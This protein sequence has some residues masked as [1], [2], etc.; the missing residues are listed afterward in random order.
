[1]SPILPHFSPNWDLHNAF[2][3]G[4]LQHSSDVGCGP[5]IAV[6]SSH[7]VSWWP[8]TPECQ[9][10]VKGAWL[11]SRDPVN[12]WV[13]NANG[14]KVAKDTD[15]KFGMRTTLGESRHNHE[16]IFKMGAWS[17]SHCPINF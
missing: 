5:I 6:R 1:M 11:G 15:F 16:K 14:S 10:S 3:M 4:E 17:G 9:K 2:S 8:P 7:D 12:F 13:L